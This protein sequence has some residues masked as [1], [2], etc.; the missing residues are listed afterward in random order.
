MTK[1]RF[2]DFGAGE[3]TSAEPL[4]FK[5]HGE[6]FECWPSLQGKVLLNLAAN[7]S[8]EDGASAART[9]NEFFASALKP[10]SLERFNTLL[11]APEKIVSVET[12]ANITTWLVEEYAGRP[13]KELSGS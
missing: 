12:L 4:S 11:E 3:A 2:K 1:N 6:E 7:S 8:E 5:L 9:M 10:E 13:T